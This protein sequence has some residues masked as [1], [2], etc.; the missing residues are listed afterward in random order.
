MM[1][2]GQVVACIGLMACDLESVFDWLPQGGFINTLD[3]GEDDNIFKSS[4]VRPA[5]T[6]QL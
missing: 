2:I 4:R 5:A 1:S 6:I 3:W